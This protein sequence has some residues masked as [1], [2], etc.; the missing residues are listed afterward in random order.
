MMYDRY[1]IERIKDANPVEAV[2][3][4]EI[5][6]KRSGK[7]LV[8]ECPFCTGKKPKLTVT[9]EK[10]M[11]YCFRCRE[12]GDVVKWIQLRQN[13]KFNEALLHLVRR[14]GIEP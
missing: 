1:Q 8:G 13:A 2:I 6:L 11:W 4:D 14:A 9:P 7:S 10:Q 3:G 12:G 5:P